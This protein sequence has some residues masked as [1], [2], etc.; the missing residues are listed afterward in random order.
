M[1]SSKLKVFI[2][3]MVREEVAM[4]I[5]EVIT[6]MKQPPLSSKPSRAKVIGKKTYS[7][8]SVLNEVL[9]E[10]ARTA[11]LEGGDNPLTKMNSVMQSSYGDMMNGTSD[12]P[13]EDTSDMGQFLNKDYSGLMAAMDKKKEHFRP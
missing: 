10:T 2:R 12:V 1:K 5:H 8:N 3:K 6:E 13:V 7:T 11:V 4:A 9:N